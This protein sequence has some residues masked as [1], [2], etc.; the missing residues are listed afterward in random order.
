MIEEAVCTQ[1]NA[2]RV[3][4]LDH[5]C[6]CC[7]AA[8]LA[9]GG[10]LGGALNDA[11]SLAFQILC[12]CDSALPLSSQHTGPRSV[13]QRQRLQSRGAA[14]RRLDRARSDRLAR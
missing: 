9:G 7:S 14:E 3:S 12:S 6:R 4:G 13:A 1:A 5:R 8:S 2:E 11:C 10:C